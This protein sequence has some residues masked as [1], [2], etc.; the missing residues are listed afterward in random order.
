MCASSWT[1]KEIQVASEAEDMG[2]IE[3]ND[4]IGNAERLECM[5]AREAGAEGTL[6]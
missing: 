5:G 3:I 4:I 2:Q 6:C 1:L